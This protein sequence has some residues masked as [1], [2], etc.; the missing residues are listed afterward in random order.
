M[1]AKSGHLRHL[2][3]RAGFKTRPRDV[4]LVVGETRRVQGWKLHISS[5]PVEAK[6][7]LEVVL[8]VLLEA[9]APF[10]LVRDLDALVE[11][12]GGGLGQSQVGKFMTI[13][14][15]SDVDS[16]AIAARLIETTRG[17]HGPIIPSDIRLGDV[18]Y[19]RHGGF[20][21]I[22]TQDRLG[23][24][25]LLI[26][27]E[28]GQLRRD[29][30]ALPFQNDGLAHSPFLSMAAP[31]TRQRRLTD[32]GPA[33]GARLVGPGYRI[34]DAI[35]VNTTGSVLLA[36]DLRQPEN[37][38]LRVLKEGRPFCHADRAG[39]DIRT[40][41]RH[42]AD[43]LSLIA[44]LKVA[45]ECYG[46]FEDRGIGYLALDHIEGE[47]VERFAYAKLGDRPWVSLEVSR[48]SELLRAAKS[49][50][51]TVA[52]LHGAGVVHRDLASANILIQEDGTARLI[53]FGLAY[54]LGSTDRPFLTG[55][56]GF[57]SPAQAAQKAP[58]F[59][60][61]VY[62]VG[63]LMI[64]L[65]TSLDPRR[66]LF[67]GHEKL[68][69]RMAILMGARIGPLV[70][71]VVRCTDSRNSERPSLAEIAGVL[72]R[73]LSNLRAEEKKAA[74][75]STKTSRP[76]A[77]GSVDELRTVLINAA[78]SLFD[79]TAVTRHDGIWLSLRQGDHEANHSA[80][81][82]ICRDAYRGVAGPLYVL[83]R[84][85]REGF[86]V[87]QDHKARLKR[88]VHNL[89]KDNPST[90]TRLPGLYF[91]RAGEAV[92]L[93][94]LQLSGLNA[95][96]PAL[97]TKILARTSAEFDWPDMTHGAAG[98]GLAALQL[99]DLQRDR[100]FE[101][102]ARA[103]ADYLCQ[104]QSTD[105]GWILPGSISGLSGQSLTGFAHGSAGILYFL[106][107]YVA[108]TGS[109]LAARALE[110][111][112]ECLMRQAVPAVGA[113][114]WPYS[115][116]NPTRWRWWCHGSPG[117]ALTFLRLYERSKDER[118]ADAACRALS[119]Q[120]AQVR[121]GNLGQCHGLA[122]LG[123]V[124]LEAARVLDDEAFRRRAWDI[125]RTILALGRRDSD[126]RLSW[127]VE[128]A[129][130]VTADLMV[131]TSGLFHFLLRLACPAAPMGPPLL[132]GPVRV[133][134]PV[135]AAG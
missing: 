131:G 101:A 127:L 69:D 71:L 132:S 19:A 44:H 109:G 47:S 126:G 100:R 90:K 118:H 36:L 91:G 130:A 31:S 55:T 26:Y 125:A 67:A 63:C 28:D 56:P 103:A 133:T 64:L 37:L 110:R 50:V 92:A 68:A 61:D 116:K 21:P 129:H 134:A 41:L 39:R 102:I 46:Y 45:P 77:H 85:T 97:R 83:A 49:I 42:E 84:L 59:A 58:S 89:V 8:P 74:L 73:A 18:V 117:I 113:D 105:G 51:D 104:N 32:E 121:A 40:R 80:G 11:L 123:E 81:F 96:T 5:V 119:Q 34:V 4:W 78:A 14:P 17:F 60:D 94:E 53:D 35:E 9:G 87:G 15:E 115:D 93:A 120:S 72:D 70:E 16:R 43:I 57:M 112:I 62:S 13:Y 12:N 25:Q 124:Y 27:G 52:K 98:Q 88:A 24:T 23:H 128:G 54:I 6:R 111:G 29:A 106:V 114:E 107:E 86:P 30:Y 76:T 48:R 95:D 38:G 135:T 2:L 22:V 1:K 20:A 33:S 65:L 82:E 108:T 75:Q 122:G 10:K 99:M 79:A 3:S 7:L 66:V